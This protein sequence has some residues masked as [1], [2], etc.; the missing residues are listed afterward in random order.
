[1]GSRLALPACAA[2]HAAH[3]LGGAVDALDRLLEERVD[4]AEQV[5]VLGGGRHHAQLLP[6]PFELREIRAHERERVVD[7]VRDAG[8]ELAHRGKPRRRDQLAAQVGELAQVAHDDH[9]AERASDRIG[10]RC[11][12]H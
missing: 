10:K 6:D 11:R 2:S 4:V 8:R 7:L 12:A 3:D 9:A 5:G 1:V